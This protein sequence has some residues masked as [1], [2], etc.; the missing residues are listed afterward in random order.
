[1]I[2]VLES[3]APA[4][5]KEFALLPVTPFGDGFIVMNRDAYNSVGTER[6]LGCYVDVIEDASGP[7]WPVRPLWTAV[8]LPLPMFGVN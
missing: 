8:Q 2:A 6:A 4:S 3:P 7:Y 1:M 5:V